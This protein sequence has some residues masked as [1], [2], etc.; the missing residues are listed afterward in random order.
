MWLSYINNSG[1]DRITA[2]INLIDILSQPIVDEVRGL[3]K[4]ETETLRICLS[5]IAD[6]V[7]SFVRDATRGVAVHELSE[8]EVKFYND[9]SW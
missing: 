5:C 3:F 7:M 4:P 6:Y 9:Q 8:R 2:T 1:V